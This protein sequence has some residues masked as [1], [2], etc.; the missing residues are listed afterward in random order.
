MVRRLMGSG[1]RW[2]C[3][4]AFV[5]VG[6]KDTKPT[7]SR[8]YRG[9]GAGAGGENAEVNEYIVKHAREDVAQIEQKLPSKSASLYD[10]VV[11][12]ELEKIERADKAL[13]TKLKRLCTYE[14]P[15]SLIEKALAV[16]EPARKAQPDAITIDGCDV[17]AGLSIEEMEKYGTLDDRAKALIQRLDAACPLLAKARE[18]R[19]TRTGTGTGSAA[20]PAP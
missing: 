4:V 20:P 13:A 10:C 19:T 1:I 18:D 17:D 9:G 7:G 8:P 2:V 16:A 3:A 12:T 15:V 5:M 14:V 11:M 6:C